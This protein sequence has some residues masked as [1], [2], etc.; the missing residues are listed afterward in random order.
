MPAAG[1]IPDQATLEKPPARRI[2]AIQPDRFRISFYQ[3]SLSFQKTLNSVPRLQ[4]RIGSSPILGK[5][6]GFHLAYRVCIAAGVHYHSA[7]QEASTTLS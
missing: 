3:L 4:L 2:A 5:T 1:N 6:P 7:F